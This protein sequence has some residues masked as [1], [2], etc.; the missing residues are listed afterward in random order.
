MVFK[1]N[2]CE[3]KSIVQYIINHELFHKQDDDSV[4]SLYYK[5][6]SAFYTFQVLFGIK[7]VLLT[8]FE[9]DNEKTISNI[10]SYNFDI[11]QIKNEIGINHS[12]CPPCND[13]WKW[14]L[15]FVKK[16]EYVIYGV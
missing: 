14:I 6:Q 4:E 10:F 3:H 12:I 2:R 15:P 5:K 7:V 9:Y 11:H 16:M 8:L 13:A 1:M